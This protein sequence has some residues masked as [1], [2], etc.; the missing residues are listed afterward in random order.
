MLNVL[1][2][3]SEDRKI[4][5]F[6][7]L[8]MKDVI[9]LGRYQYSY[10]HN[11]LPRHTHG[12]SYEFCYMDEG[13]QPY[14]IGS[15][16]YVLKGGEV[17][18]VFPNENH[19]SGQAPEYRGRLYWLILRAP[20]PGETFLELSPGETRNL[21]AALCSLSPRN[22]TG[23]SFLKFY[24]EKIFQSYAGSSPLKC[25]EIRSL[26]IRFL[27]DIISDCKKHKEHQISP[28]IQDIQEYISQ[29]LYKENISLSELA[30]RAN[31]S[32]P[33]F[34]ARFKEEV[35]AAPA[36]YILHQ[37]ISEAEKLLKE[38]DSKIIQ[39]AMDLG[40][41]TSQYFAT[42]FKRYT[43]STPSEFRVKFL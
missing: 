28:L 27:L 34:K 23:S 42:T 26:V 13:I 16:E 5:D 9:A 37:K 12:D 8:G 14:V 18:A 7:T 36:G 2:D 10:A 35:G 11:Q 22:F 41:S 33:R 32:L 38:T 30:S 39:I 29:N 3:P 24:L 19:S 1:I 6:R 17:L 21:C 4:V 25:L 20:Q 43:G 31:L 15:E 40:F